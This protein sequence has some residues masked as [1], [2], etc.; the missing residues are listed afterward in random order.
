VSEAILQIAQ[1]HLRKV[2]R[3]GN[4]NVMGLCPFHRKADGSEERDPSFAINIFSGL[5]YCHSCH[6]RGNLYTFLRDVG[7]PRASIDFYYKSAIEDAER[8]APPRP[9]PLH[10]I[11]PTKEP[12]AES[13]LGLFDMC[14][15]LLLD[16]GFDETLLRQFDVGFDEAHMRITFPLRNVQG[17]LV[18]ISGRTV[19]DATPRYKVYDKEYLDFG[20]PSRET[21]KR[22]LLWNAHNVITQLAFET[23]P[24]ERYVVVTEGFK[25]TM[26]VVQGGVGN[27]VG[28]LGSY[29]ST[30]QHWLLERLGCPILLMFDNNEAGRSGQLDA[31]L[32]LVKTVP[33]LFIVEYNAGQPSDLSTSAI[34]HALLGAQPFATW[35]V[36]HNSH[37]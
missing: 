12:L 19:V 28:L 17:K 15:Q 14:P 31:A 1:Q 37:P 18:G 24:G 7:I 9:D 27:A 2:K 3:T 34:P 10:P 20:L 11:E 8:Y 29:M 13:L 21:Q 22:A 4:E 23:D 16:E 32:R 5:W 6:L 26:R 36:H 35:F 30:E 33:R 25:S